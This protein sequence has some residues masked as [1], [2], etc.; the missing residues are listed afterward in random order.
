MEKVKNETSVIGV[1]Q[2]DEESMQEQDTGNLTRA[3]FMRW[4]GLSQSW[5]HVKGSD[6]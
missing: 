4:N 6:K 3:S 1:N 5:E 2:T